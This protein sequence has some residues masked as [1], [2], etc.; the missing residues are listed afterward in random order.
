MLI[1]EG[2]ATAQTMYEATGIPTVI[3]YNAGNLAAVSKVIAEISPNSKQVFAADNDHHLP[4]KDTPLPNLGKE[5]AEAAAREV[6]GVVLLPRFDAI[7]KAEL[8]D[9]KSPPTDWNDYAKL[10]GKDVLKATIEVSL[11]EEGIAMPTKRQEASERGPLTQ[12]ERDAGRATAQPNA[13][14]QAASQ[15]AAQRDMQRQAEQ[16]RDESR[17]ARPVAD[18]YDRRLRRPHPRR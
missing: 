15:A 18:R 7:E 4:R 5:K 1:A 14:T 17:G 2:V 8:V 6:G 13:Q 11:R 9:G 10:F 3:A 12:A 16:Q